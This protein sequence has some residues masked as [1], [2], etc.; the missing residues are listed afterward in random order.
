MVR[1]LWG[2]LLGL[3]LMSDALAASVYKCTDADGKVVYTDKKC[4]AET[5]PQRIW[6]NKLGSTAYPVMFSG[7]TPDEARAVNSGQASA[8]TDVAETPVESRRDGGGY[9][10]R[11]GRKSWVQDTPCPSMINE[12]RTTVFTH[13]DGTSSSMTTDGASHVHQEQLSHDGLCNNLDAAASTYERNRMAKENG[14]R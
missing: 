6:D 9:L 14:C 13:R 5:A 4:A 1:G 10:C 12:E 3:A 7:A 2:V 11:T 8:S